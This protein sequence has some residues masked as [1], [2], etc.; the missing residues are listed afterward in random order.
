MKTVVVGGRGFLGGAVVSELRRRGD[1][2]AIVDPCVSQPEC[3]TMFGRGSVKAIAGDMMRPAELARA[4]EG[5]DEVYHMG[6]KLGTSELDS[7]VHE[8]IAANITGAVNVFD[9][10]VAAGVPTLFYPTKP[11]VWLNAYTITKVAAEQFARIY[12]ARGTIRIQSLRYFNAYGPGQALGPVRKIIPMFT[13]RAL[14]RL[15]IIVYGD[16]EQTVDMIHSEDVGRITVAFTRSA[17]DGAAIDCGRGVEL[18]VN[19]VADMVNRI[20]ANPAGRVHV[21]MRAG[22][23]EG[24]RLVADI[25]PLKAVLPDLSFSDWESTLADTIEWYAR[26]GKARLAVAAEAA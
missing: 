15:P 3:D 18:T 4:F 22:E 17:Y 21:P 12:A 9:A 7:M 6:G 16:G 23:T 8:A 5:A 2:V 26:L 13:A 14:N 1:D 25:A 20:T 24:T 19:A 10:A 11:N